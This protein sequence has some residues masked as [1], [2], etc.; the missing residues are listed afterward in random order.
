MT[1]SVWI[2]EGDSG[3]SVDIKKG[4]NQFLTLKADP[5]VNLHFPPVGLLRMFLQ[6]LQATTVWAWLKTTAV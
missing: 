1:L 2:V 6:L 5:S 3:D 4:Y